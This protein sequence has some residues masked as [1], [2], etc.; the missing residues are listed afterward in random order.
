MTPTPEAWPD[1]LAE[2]IAGFP[3]GTDTFLNWQDPNGPG[4]WLEVAARVLDAHG[5]QQLAQLALECNPL[6]CSPAGLAV[7]ERGLGLA[8]SRVAQTGSADLRRLQVITKL[9]DRGAPTLARIR[10]VVA[11]LLGYSAMDSLVILE[12]DRA[13]L[14]AAH[15][16]WWR[17]LLSLFTTLTWT[18]ADHPVVSPAGAQVD[19]DLTISSLGYLKATLT[20]PDGRAVVRQDLGRDALTA[21]RTF[22]TP[23]TTPFGADRQ[24]GAVRLSD[25]TIWTV[26]AN[27]TSYVYD[28]TADTWT[29]VTTGTAKTLW[30][31]WGTRI[32]VVGS[33]VTVLWAVGADGTILLGNGT[34][35][36]ASASGTTET[37]YGVWG[38]GPS[39]VW[40]V[41]T[42]T[43]TLHWDGAAWTVVTTL[44]ASATLYG[45]SGS[46]PADVWAVGGTT[47]WN[48]DGGTWR[49]TALSMGGVSLRAVWAAAP[50]DAWAVGDSGVVVRYGAGGWVAYPSVPGGRKLW[51]VWGT[52][53]ADVWV[54]GDDATISYWNGS[55]WTEYSQALTSHGQAIVGSGGLV[56]VVGDTVWRLDG[57]AQANVRLYY[58]E[59]AGTLIGGTWSLLLEQ[60]GG[61]GASV[62]AAGLFAEGLGVV[63]DWRG[64][65]QEGRGGQMYQWGPVVE[66]S[67]LG[68]DADL[69]AALDALRRLNYARSQVE[70]IRRS[71]GPKALPAGK[72]GA[73]ASDP[74]AIASACVAG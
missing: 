16:Y 30:G 6:T 50:G 39:D 8:G 37:L 68:P 25:G 34:A 33:W 61:G 43:T 55:T 42:N 45:V 27:G 3:P 14:R 35:W 19:L 38:S 11:P 4:P 18:V 58:P 67:K 15:T 26:G 13:A 17:G 5:E 48:W 28:P 72:W 31:V 49:V 70:L 47:A 66:P 2:L 12:P 65:R 71:S 46:G 63:L 44:A 10:G 36:T 57:R 69:A 40:A 59:M 24:N 22:T 20:S 53:P 29:A 23:W 54:V 73:I 62:R 56:Y 52:G 9:R 41:G 7:W 64:G 21:A 1:L 74:G 51:A 60:T 32:L